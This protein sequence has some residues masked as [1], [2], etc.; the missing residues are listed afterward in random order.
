MSGR[1]NFL[2]QGKASGKGSNSWKTATDDDADQAQV[3]YLSQRMKKPTIRLVQ[4]GMTQITLC[5]RT[6]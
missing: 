5:S 1:L 4:L 6:V 3:L 2:N